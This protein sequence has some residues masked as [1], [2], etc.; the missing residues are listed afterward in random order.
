MTEVGRLLQLAGTA[1]LKAL[2]I[3]KCGDKISR[4]AL[5]DRMTS[6]LRVAWLGLCSVSVVS[7]RL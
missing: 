5:N 6:S 7:M 2:K 4:F 3:V 1:E